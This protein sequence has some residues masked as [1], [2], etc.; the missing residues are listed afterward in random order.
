MRPRFSI[1]S[2]AIGQNGGM[3]RMR[4]PARKVTWA[5]LLAGML[6]GGALVEA[7]APT[8]VSFDR[9]RPGTLPPGFRVLSSNEQESGRWQVTRQDGRAVLSQLEVG[10]AGYRLAV[11]ESPKVDHLRAGVRLRMA[12]GDRAAGLAWRVTDAHNYY[13]ARLDLDSREFILYKFVRGN[14]VRLS[15]VT[16]LRL[17]DDR[18]HELAVE[19]VRDSIKVWLNGIPV[20]SER[21]EALPGAGMI[22][23]W[24]PGDSSAH[25]TGL[26]FDP[27]RVP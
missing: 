18:W 2:G 8:V 21:D 23:V 22:G 24:L 6:I 9:V 7:D 20:A 17:K 1:P 11:L 15:R 25:F 16:D 26:W 19:H 3:L 27:V 10:G 5:L 12:A 13:A 14:R 4:V